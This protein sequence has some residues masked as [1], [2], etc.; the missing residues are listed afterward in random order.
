MNKALLIIPATAG[1]FCAGLAAGIWVQRTPPLPAPPTDLMGELLDRA[2]RDHVSVQAQAPDADHAIAELQA[3]VES[4][5]AEIDLFRK[6]F[7]PIKTEFNQGLNAILTPEQRT[8]FAAMVER[9]AAANL[10]GPDG[11]PNRAMEPIDSMIPIVIVPSSLD[12]LTEELKLTEEQRASVRLLL[13]ARRA[14]FLKLVDD[15][16]PPSLKLGRIAPLIPSIAKPDA[17]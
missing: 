10:R 16:P 6:K 5:K 15:S 3:Q 11:K 2:P 13:I 12:R 7:E 1:V 4:L 14:Q 8:R 9:G 17:K